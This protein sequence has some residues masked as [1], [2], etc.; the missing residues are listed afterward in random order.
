MFRQKQ[1]LKLEKPIFFT[2]KKS[3][4][5]LSWRPCG[6][7]FNFDSV[8]IKVLDSTH[9]VIT[10]G[11]CQEVQRFGRKLYARVKRS[12]LE[13]GEYELVGETENGYYFALKRR[14]NV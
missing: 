12:A 7:F 8:C 2:V 11:S 5:Y 9:F 6:D 3:A 10:P 13:N 14:E 1:E 4:S